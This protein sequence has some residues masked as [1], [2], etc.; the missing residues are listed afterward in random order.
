MNVATCPHCGSQFQ[1]AGAGVV[2]RLLD[3]VPIPFHDVPGEA[4]VDDRLG[5][6]CPADT[7]VR[8]RREA[9]RTGRT[10][11]IIWR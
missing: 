5:C 6:G 3:G 9:I 2:M 8:E 11:T 7:A 10:P 1:Y 4:H